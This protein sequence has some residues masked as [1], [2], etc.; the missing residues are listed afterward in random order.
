MT[1]E[2]IVV[3]SVAFVITAGRGGKRLRVK[4]ACQKQQGEETYDDTSAHL[5]PQPNYQV[6]TQG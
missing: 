1:E 5:R 4:R 6:D 3:G 2:P